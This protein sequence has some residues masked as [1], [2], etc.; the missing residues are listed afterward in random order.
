VFLQKYFHNRPTTQELDEY[1]VVHSRIVLDIPSA[2]EA[3][4]L[5]S[6]INN[7]SLD[8]NSICGMP[9]TF[10]ISPTLALL[11][12]V[13]I[14]S[15]SYPNFWFEGQIGDLFQD[16]ITVRTN[17]DDIFTYS[18]IPSLLFLLFSSPSLSSL[19]SL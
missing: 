12:P 2:V 17:A 9:N 11:A 13:L 5:Y 19:I 7:G 3:G 15:D 10:S 1:T 6:P 14:L 16:K 18:L 8:K 4:D